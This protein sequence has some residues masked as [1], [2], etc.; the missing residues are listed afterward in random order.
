LLINI[1]TERIN[2]RRYIAEVQSD[3]C[4]SHERVARAWLDGPRG[5]EF[6]DSQEIA[7]FVTLSCYIHQQQANS[8][9][10]RPTT[11]AA[12]PKMSAELI[13]QSI[14]L[15]P[16]V[17][18][19]LW[20]SIY[21]VVDSGYWNAAQWKQ[22][23]R[24]NGSRYE[25][26]QIASACLLSSFITQL[27]TGRRHTRNISPQ[28]RMRFLSEVSSR[29]ITDIDWPKPAAEMPLMDDRTRWESRPLCFPSAS[30]V[31]ALAHLINE[32][33]PPPNPPDTPSR[34]IHS[35]VRADTPA[36]YEAE[37][38]TPVHTRAKSLPRDVPT[39]N[40]EDESQLTAP[41]SSLPEPQQESQNPIE[42]QHPEADQDIDDAESLRSGCEDADDADRDD[43]D[44]DD[45]TRSFYFNPVTGEYYEK[46]TIDA[47]N[48]MGMSV[49]LEVVGDE[50][51][52]TPEMIERAQHICSM[53]TEAD[54]AA[55]AAVLEHQN[56]WSDITSRALGHG[57]LT[58]LGFAS[59]ALEHLES[60]DRK[61][62]K[63]L[64]YWS[65]KQAMI[66]EAIDQIKETQ[67][68]TKENKERLARLKGTTVEMAHQLAQGQQEF[69]LQRA[70]DESL[71]GLRAVPKRQELTTA[72]PRNDKVTKLRE[73]LKHKNRRSGGTKTGSHTPGGFSGLRAVAG[74][75]GSTA[76]SQ[77][78]IPS[79]PSSASSNL[80][81]QM[82]L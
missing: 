71:Q 24:I 11:R 41:S 81:D 33:N 72:P 22:G 69:L 28:T 35:P 34:E 57:R 59:L 46:P 50:I 48:D 66:A 36:P 79:T 13:M 58:A 27:T 12:V 3:V 62:D 40:A 45:G 80:R 77:S 47:D 61:I 54:L 67:Q 21:D 14:S 1:E 78:A 31:P 64:L 63:H 82:G 65:E 8:L 7:R 17:V 39:V 60:L 44:S 55:I 29:M 19:A 52:V 53:D 76:G 43:D 51:L 5:Q 56:G 10:S 6:I 70:T 49:D 2:V 37:P 38:D 32:L 20:A 68:K 42:L 16:D 4:Q 75:A 25:L 74:V 23:T 26:L 73:S 30:R 18:A 15:T 9:C